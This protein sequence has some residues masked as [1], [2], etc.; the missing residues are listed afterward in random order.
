MWTE[1]I[2]FVRDLI[3]R[4]VASPAGDHV[5]L[6]LV[7]EIAA[8]VELAHG[9]NTKERKAAP[10]GTALSATDRRS[11]KVVAGARNHRDRQS[12]VVSI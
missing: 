5:E 7:G 4:I 1:A 3:E 10:R 12:L 6:K 9:G 11:V 2:E 8:M